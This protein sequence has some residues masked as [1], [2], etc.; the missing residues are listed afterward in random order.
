VA[1]DLDPGLRVT[2]IVRLADVGAE[3]RIAL[4]A[5]SSALTAI[6]LVTLLLS[7]AGVYA[8]VSLAVT[9]RTRE[10][11]VR[12]ALGAERRAILWSVLRRSVV[13]VG[14]GGVV[15]A[16]A[17]LMVSR[18]RLFVFAVPE[19]GMGLFLALVGLMAAAGTLACWVPARRALRV[20][21]M[22]ALRYD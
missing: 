3:N 10:I 4:G 5:M 15:G 21:P 16:L 1:F 17:G 11:G 22:E 20:Q 18:V 7:L 2:E 14:V 6:G 19:G 12:V 13:L 8:I 9:Q